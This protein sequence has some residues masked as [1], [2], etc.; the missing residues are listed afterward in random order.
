MSNCG[1]IT[2]P[3][4]DLCVYLHWDS[5]LEKVKPL[6]LFCKVQGS[7]SPAVDN[8]GW[9][10]ICQTYGNFVGCGSIGA[11]VDH[12][13]MM[14]DWVTDNG[15]YVIDEEWNIIERINA[16]DDEKD[17]TEDEMMKMIGYFDS[18]LPENDRIPMEYYR[19]A[20]QGR[21]PKMTYEEI[22]Y[23]RGYNAVVI[24]RARRDLREFFR[25]ADGFR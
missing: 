18:N 24:P 17:P 13:D 3:K 12:Y 15:I 2:T 19:Y 9:G 1:I 8:S 11:V 10:R 4:K 23:I 16:P 6:L 21:F 25:P 14:K 5:G 7:R 22:R 20:V